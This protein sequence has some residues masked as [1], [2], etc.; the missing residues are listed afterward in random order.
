MV[1]VLAAL[2]DDTSWNEATV[3]LGSIPTVM[4][5]EDTRTFVEQQ[6]NTFREIA[7]KLG[8]VVR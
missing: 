3:K 1:S 5:P 4:S 7:G 8:M 6:F 2:K